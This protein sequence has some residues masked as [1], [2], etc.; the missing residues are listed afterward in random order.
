MPPGVH[1]DQLRSSYSAAGILSIEAPRTVSAPE[2]ADVQEAMAAKSKAYTTD[3]GK[4]SVS[5]KSQASSQ[6]IAATTESPDGRTKS[7][8]SYSSS[9]SSSSSVVTSGGGGPFPASFGDMGMPSM[10]GGPSMNMNM[11]MDSMMKRM[12][13]NM[14]LNGPGDDLFAQMSNNRS[15]GGGLTSSFSTHSS[16]SSSTM[17]Q[18]S[19]SGLPGRGMTAMPPFSG[20]P[21]MPGFPKQHGVDIE[22]L[23]T[24][25]S[26]V[27]SPTP[28]YTVQSPPPDRPTSPPKDEHTHKVAAAPDFDYKSQRD[29]Q[30]DH[31]VLLKLREGDEY[32]L[33]LNMQQ[34][35]PEDITVKL[36]DD[37]REITVIA[38]SRGVSKEDFVQRHL[39]PPGVDL[40]KLSSSFSADGILV[41][42]APRL[43]K[44]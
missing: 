31:T 9:S 38:A 34:Y 25:G 14:S 33:V 17:Q 44:N 35:R 4:T 39:V 1:E 2:G 36:S 24:A 28:R 19:K 12:M 37:V 26:D 30:A 42:K 18:S 20:F 6:M 32:K 13:G 22:E 40:D 3:D 7:S 23:S 8:V 21:D 15:G 11:D 16:S 5:E 27:S 10:L 29:P 43:K 41:I